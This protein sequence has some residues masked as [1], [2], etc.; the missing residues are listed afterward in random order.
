M[1]FW[2]RHQ[3]DAWYFRE[4]RELHCG[5]FKTCMEEL[6]GTGRENSRRRRKKTEQ[7]KGKQPYRASECLHGVRQ[8]TKR[9]MQDTSIILLPSWW[10]L[11]VA[12][13]NQ[14]SPNF[15]PISACQRHEQT[16]STRHDSFQWCNQTW[17]RKK[18]ESYIRPYPRKISLSIN[19]PVI[20]FFSIVM[21]VQF[22][23]KHPKFSRIPSSHRLNT[24]G[25]IVNK[26]DHE[27]VYP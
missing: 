7:R 26:P 15:K 2:S 13:A 20:W 9:I 16:H 3:C 27:F 18:G 24:M 11:W 10:F 23:V 1:A 4:S 5:E 6:R 14:C 19:Y 17:T 25:P 8:M 21:L 12:T 22:I